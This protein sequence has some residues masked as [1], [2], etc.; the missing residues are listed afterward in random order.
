MRSALVLIAFSLVACGSDDS[1][2]GGSGGSAGSAGSSGDPYYDAVPAVRRSVDVSACPA[3]FQ[4][5]PPAGQNSGFDAAGQSRS[6]Y[7][8]LPSASGPRP[9]LVLFNGTGESGIEIFN[10]TQAQDF[11]DAGFIVIAPDSAGNGTLWP[12]WDG[13]REPG[14]ENDPNADLDYFDKLLD[15]VAAHYEV[16]EKRIYVG[17]HSAGGIF[18]NAVLQR[19]SQ[20]LAGG[21]PA[22]S[23]FELT[24]PSPK[25]ALDAMAVVVT[26]G[27]DNDAWGG[28]TGGTSVPEFNFVEQASIASADYEAEGAVEQAWCR[29]DNLGHAWLPANAW[30][31]D[32]L[33]GHPKGL[34]TDSPW[35]A[36]STSGTGYSCGFDVVPPPTG[37][38]V[39]CSTSTTS[40]C[41][42]YCQFL[43]DC[44]VENATIE[45]VLGPQL[46]ALGFTGTDHV[47][48]GGCVTQCEADALAGSSADP[49]VLGCFDTAFGSAQCGA[50]ISG[51]QPL[52]D[53][54]NSCCKDQT[55]SSICTRLCKTINTN[56]PASALF[57]SCAAFK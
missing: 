27:G 54:A 16:D 42:S 10:R 34:A 39:T 35:Q 3:A 4:T 47:E 51:A 11:V 14:H 30:F 55:S 9:T 33:L 28:G 50:G 1:S 24:S 17:G 31:I 26:W 41:Q 21:I 20:L 15:C 44:A 53:A 12:V 32:F 36:S 23:V 52:I 48:C 5:P 56:G 7:L 43:G 46:D 18:T 8:A 13:L 37:N 49:T 40:G 22:S 29:G 2:P 38:T 19:R 57:S 25:S 6:F 45:P